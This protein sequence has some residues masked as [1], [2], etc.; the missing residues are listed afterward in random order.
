MP[1]AS[2]AA[3]AA[4]GRAPDRAR[5]AAARSSRCARTRAASSRARRSISPASGRLPSREVFALGQ[6]QIARVE[7]QRRVGLGARAIDHRRPARR[8][9]PAGAPGSRTARSRRRRFD[10]YEQRDLLAPR[11]RGA[12]P[13]PSARLGVAAGG[14]RVA[15]A[16]VRRA[17]AGTA[18]PSAATA[19]HASERHAY[20]AIMSSAVR[21][22]IIRST[23]PLGTARHG[24]A[25]RQASRSDEA[26][27]NPGAERRRD[28]RHR[29]QDG[30]GRDSALRDAAET[31]E[32]GRSWSR[33]SGGAGAGRGGLA[34]VRDPVGRFLAEARRYKRLSETGGA[35][36]GRGGARAR[37]PERRPHAGR[38]QPAAGHLDRVPVPARLGEHPRP[39]PGGERRP[40]GGG[41][42]LGAEAGAALRHLRRLLDPRLRAALP[43]DQLA[44]DPR[45]QHARRPQAVLPA[46]EGAAEAARRRAST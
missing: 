19:A 32:R 23:P 29:P 34:T 21:R 8:R 35:R 37:R 38:A 6:E 42:A 30:R 13:A 10:E 44:A 27:L 22:V 33:T 2:R 46:G 16:T 24:Q 3:A 5:R 17:R 36:A 18:G 25:R 39:V 1:P 28:R 31:A 26:E 12:R 43:D 11:R 9:R 40:D 41:Q 14:A 7:H 15:L 4:A 20:V 45:R